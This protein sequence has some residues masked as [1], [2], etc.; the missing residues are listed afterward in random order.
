MDNKESKNSNTNT[1]EPSYRDF[2]SKIVTPSQEQSDTVKDR[3]E[4][5]R[6]KKGKPREFEVE[7]K[8]KEDVEPVKKG[9]EDELEKARRK[10][11][12]VF[13][14]IKGK[15]LESGE[16]AKE[17]D[18]ELEIE[19]LKPPKEEWG[20]IEGE[21]NLNPEEKKEFQDVKG[22][23]EKMP[24]KDRWNLIRGVANL[25]Y[26]TQEWKGNLFNKA[27]KKASS[28]TKDKGTIQE[29]GTMRRFLTSYAEKY[30]EESKQAKKLREKSYLTKIQK[31]GGLLKLGGNVLKYGRILWDLNY[32]NPLRHVM[33][34]S[35]FVGRSAEVAKEA[36][37]KSAKSIEKT[38]VKGKDEA[39]EEAWQIYQEAQEKAETGQEISKEDLEKEYQRILPRD[40]KK[41]LRENTDMS[42][43]IVRVFAEEHV[44]WSVSRI[45]NKI[46]KIEK[47]KK[48][49]PEKKELKKEK[50]LA[51][52][53]KK[54]EDLDRM[55]SQ[56]GSINL[57]AYL[58]RATEKTGKAVSIG[59]M[60]DTLAR[61]PQIFASFTES[62][63]ETELSEAPLKPRVIR[64]K[65]VIPAE[66]A[67]LPRA[68]AKPSPKI[69]S[70]IAPE[71]DEPVPVESVKMEV[72]RGDSPLRL[73]KKMYVQRA[74]QLGYDSNI[75]G[76]SVSKWA[77][78]FSTRH[79]IGQ[80]LREHQE[81]YSDLID[82][83]GEPP[84]DPKELDQWISGVPK[85]TF[86]DILNNKVPNL[87]HQGD[88][89]TITENGD[90]VA[91]SPENEVR[92]GHIKTGDSI[93]DDSLKVGEVPPAG[94]GKKLI[95]RISEKADV[96]ERVDVYRDFLKEKGFSNVL[97]VIGDNSNNGDFDAIVKIDGEEITLEFRNNAEEIYFKK[98]GVKY[99]L[100]GESK[101]N[102]KA[103]K[104]LIEK[105]EKAA[106]EPKI[107]EAPE[108][109][110][111]K[112]ETDSETINLDNG[113]V[114]I[115]KDPAGNSE[116]FVGG[117]KSNPELIRKVEDEIIAKK[118]DGS[119]N[120]EIKHGPSTPN[121]MILARKSVKNGGIARYIKYQA[122]EKAQSEGKTE[123]AKTIQKSLNNDLRVMKSFYGNVF[124]K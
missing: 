38:R 94:P 31:G 44:N 52:Q 73:A 108:I 54:L 82:K 19:K 93:L 81:D 78:R 66:E 122:L 4:D 25:G 117:I 104:E 61:L 113:R 53:K 100:S 90:I 29:S 50:L 109:P 98:D 21:A 71:L 60:A 64:K 14:K 107:P 85:D 87:V 120:I 116:V 68:V 92:T 83:I 8:K 112:M 5:W 123:L 76:D 105:V 36:R 96:G 2:L 124:K 106:V 22:E 11:D 35:M 15:K 1:N 32:A 65:I 23:I 48:L 13:G 30:K 9:D 72:G 115:Y 95:E 34:A 51:R 67:E 18:L 111:T 84:L 7:D 69:A 118:P 12:D 16:I 3:V 42:F 37:L 114:E 79:L 88:R 33:A 45:N 17:N 77:E 97:S 86:N 20:K 59:M 10:I 27:F 57:L 28:L 70:R 6:E 63:I 43:N 103:V 75:H 110:E 101:I 24:R 55:V 58:S 39:A 91:Y 74:E 41:R 99:S 26:L 40:L 119:Y 56:T 89:V 62:S 102:Q 121:R 47:N 49:S 46:A 80:Y